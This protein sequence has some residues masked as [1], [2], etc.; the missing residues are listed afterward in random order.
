M[1]M[2]G[3]ILINKGF[4]T[5]KQLDFGLKEQKSRPGMI[6]EILVE[7]GFLNEEKLFQALIDQLPKEAHT[8]VNVDEGDRI[9]READVQSEVL[10]L[11]PRDVM[12][13]RKACPVWLSV[14]GKELVVAMAIAADTEGIQEI[15]GITG[16]R[17]KAVSTPLPEI[18]SLWKEYF[19]LTPHEMYG[20]EL[21]MKKDLAPYLRKDA[22]ERAATELV[23]KLVNKAFGFGASDIH[24]DPY[25]E[26]VLIRLRLDGV[27][28]PAATIPRELYVRVVTR[29]KVLGHMDISEH[30]MTQDGRTAFKGERGTKI[31]LRISI[32]PVYHGERIV[33]RLFDRGQLFFDVR[34]LG[35]HHRD[36]TKFRRELER[37]NGLVLI[38]GPTGSGKTTTLYSMINFLNDTSRNI[39]SIEDPVEFTFRGV[40]QIQVDSKNGVT[41]ASA[42]RTVLRQDPNVIMVGEI[43][44]EETAEICVRASLTGHLVLATAHTNDAASA[45]ARMLNMGVKPYLLASSLSMVLAQRLARR[46][47]AHCKVPDRPDPRVLLRMGI[48]PREITKLRFSRGKGCPACSS[49]G[50]HGRVAL[51]ETLFFSPRL[52]ELITQNASTDEL[53]AQARKERMISL[54]LDGVY[55]A[56]QGQ[57]TL[58]EVVKHAY[59]DA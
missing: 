17:V 36:F 26:E 23:E 13:K 53:R 57:T 6:G 16:K 28:F 25:E 10:H 21:D 54:V 3:Q 52:R 47:C 24:F 41:F 34:Q 19:S 2:L 29:V 7:Q 4:I 8:I 22:G 31:D 37:P 12:V 38:T 1:S 58:D 14:D 55:K 9:D 49:L 18:E 15:E 43:R 35:V 27:L 40:A 42:L 48:K 5:A 45:I 44:D 11:V 20:A 50:Y 59:F 30:R 39:M 51:I 32:L 56:R 46:V 33:M